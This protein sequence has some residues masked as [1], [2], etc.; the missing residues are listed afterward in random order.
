MLLKKIK[1]KKYLF[2]FL[3]AVR[4]HTLRIHMY[5]DTINNNTITLIRTSEHDVI[6]S[7]DDNYLSVHNVH[8]YQNIYSSPLKCIY[9]Y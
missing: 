8:T 5:C 7:I 1:E 3:F 4:M 2:Y 9:G 6:R